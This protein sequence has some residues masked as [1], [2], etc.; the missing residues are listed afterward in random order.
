MFY[1][2]L[3]YFNTYLD[4]IKLP[5]S[6]KKMTYNYKNYNRYVSYAEPSDDE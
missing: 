3:F 6:T 5:L 1:F 4:Q 2:T